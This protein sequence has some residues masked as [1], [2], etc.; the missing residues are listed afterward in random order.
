MGEKRR[1]RGEKRKEGEGTAPLTQL[2]GSASGHFVFNTATV[3]LLYEVVLL[4]GR[5]ALFYLFMYTV[6]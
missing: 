1:S 2:P 3:S 6:T 5:N 4:D